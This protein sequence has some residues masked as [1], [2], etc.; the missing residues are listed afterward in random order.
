M[1]I[2]GL[3]TG[4]ITPQT[5]VSCPGSAVIYNRRFMCWKKGG[6]GT[7]DVHRALVQ[8]CNVFYYLL[9]KKAGI[10]AITKYAKMFGIGELSGI[11]IPGESRGNP[12]SAE[13]KQ[14]VHKEPWYP[15]DT[16]SVSIGQGL[17]AV[18]PV[19][20]ATMI[21]AVANGG[22]L[23]RPHLAKDARSGS[24]KLPVSAGTL[25][26]IREAL[27]DVVEEGTATRA[28]LG[29]IRVAGKTG[30][31]QVFKKSVGVDADKQPKEER[32]HAWFIGYAPADK[33]EIAFAIVIEHGG[34]GG[35]TAAPVARKVLE[36]FFEDRLP[37]KE[38]A[39][40]LQAKMTA[41]PEAARAQTTAA[42]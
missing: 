25:A 5:V 13:W 7:V 14:R 36:V 32:D 34:H 23:V 38:P 11:D 9:G 15:G 1:S 17:L 2:V 29:P 4:A 19:Q 26:L 24:T 3:E 12:P 22:T 8:S 18:T 40:A 21:S 42:R 39:P 28:Q 31:A 35:T 6:H 33:Q 10:D 27:A 30:T 41:R 20:M 16:I 37:E